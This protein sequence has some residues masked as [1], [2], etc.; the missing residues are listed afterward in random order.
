[1]DVPNLKRI[2]TS[3]GLLVTDNDTRLYLNLLRMFRKY[4]QFEGEFLETVE[5]EDLTSSKRLAHTL[6]G[7]AGSIGAVTLQEKSYALEK[8]CS[9]ELYKKELLEPYLN[10]V[11]QELH[12]ILEE[13][14]EIPEEEAEIQNDKEINL[15][16]VLD[17]LENIKE[18]ADSFDVDAIEEFKV[19]QKMDGMGEYKLF[20][21]KAKNAFESYDFESAIET[22]NE[23][24]ADLT[25]RKGE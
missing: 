2:D 13:L 16:K 3:K 5:S 8:F 18:L 21:E 10:E 11:L 4:K 6:K 17:Q 15:E 7:A 20:M 9:Q 22:M 19:L 14:Q 23:L 12:L 24:E 1:M 25:K